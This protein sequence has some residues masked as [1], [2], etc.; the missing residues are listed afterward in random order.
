MVFHSLDKMTSLFIHLSPPLLMYGLRYKWAGEFPL[1]DPE[2]VTFFDMYIRSLPLYLLWQFLYWLKGDYFRKVVNILVY[3]VSKHKVDR[4]TSARWLLGP[5]KGFIYNMSIKLYGEKYADYGK[6]VPNEV[7]MIR[8]YDLAI[9][10]HYSS[11]SAMLVL[12]P[13]RSSV[14]PLY[15]ICW[16][17][18]D[19]EWCWVLL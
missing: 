4:V 15:C 18:F 11:P 10:L 19:L 13:I 5:K 3:V 7:S 17:N 8:V 2:T 6:R 9:Y 16:R 12:L 1:P 14:L